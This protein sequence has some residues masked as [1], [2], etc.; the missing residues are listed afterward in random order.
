V[1]KGSVNGGAYVRA[2]NLHARMWRNAAQSAL[3]GSWNPVTFDTVGEDD[4][5]LWG[6]TPPR[7]VLPVAGTWRFSAH[8]CFNTS[9]SSWGGAALYVNG[10]S[11]VMSITTAPATAP[12]FIVVPLTITKRFAASDTLALYIQSSPALV[13]NVGQYTFFITCEYVCI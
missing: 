4:Y 11:T 8:I 12:P 1:A 2:T 10:L 5:G 3:L 7:F 6:A 9:G 13:G